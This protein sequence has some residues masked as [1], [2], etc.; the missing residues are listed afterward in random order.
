LL[1]LIAHREIP[2]ASLPGAA[3]NVQMQWTKLDP[4]ATLQCNVDR[5]DG[6]SLTV[7]THHD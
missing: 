7:P 3:G 1:F 5:L 6:N 4:G 2:R